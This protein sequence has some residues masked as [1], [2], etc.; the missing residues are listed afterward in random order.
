MARASSH[1]L[2]VQPIPLA[3]QLSDSKKRGWARIRLHL[4][5]LLPARRGV[6]APLTQRLVER[7]GVGAGTEPCFACQG[8]IANLAALAV[9]SDEGDK[10]TFSVWRCRVCFTLYLSDWVDRWERLESLETEETIYRLAPAEALEML[11][12]IDS[13]AGGDHPGQRSERNAPKEWIKNQ[14]R[15]RTPLSHM[16]KQGR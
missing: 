4:R 12:L 9:E 1:Q 10:E 3:A 14:V 6:S 11:A 13:I 5:R 2:P 16:V 15:G 7:S 8:R